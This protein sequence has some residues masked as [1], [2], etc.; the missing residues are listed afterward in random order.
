MEDLKWIL[1]I[2]K[3]LLLSLVMLNLNFVSPFLGFPLGCLIWL[4]IF[5]FF[6]FANHNEHG[7]DIDKYVRALPQEVQDKIQK[8]REDRLGKLAEYVRLSA[9][10]QQDNETLQKE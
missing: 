3:F 10:S 9:E 1:I 6:N 7:V 8:S 5:P 2:N 4:D